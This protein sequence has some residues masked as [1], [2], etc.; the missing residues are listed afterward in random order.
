MLEL[1]KCC[2]SQISD[3]TNGKLYK[4]RY[5]LFKVFNLAS[6][7]KKIFFKSTHPSEGILRSAKD[8]TENTKTAWT[9]L[10]STV[11]AVGC[12]ACCKFVRVKGIT[13]P[14][15]GVLLTPPGSFLEAG[16]QF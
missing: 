11:E 14:N 5:A 2:R 9:P 1:A 8:Q 3:E 10:D 16:A 7:I 13:L 12:S 15:S 6:Q 4:N